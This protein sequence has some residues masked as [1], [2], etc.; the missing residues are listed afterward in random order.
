MDFNDSQQEAEFRKEAR[1][2]LE[3]NAEKRS[4]I[5]D[6]PNDTGSQVAVAGAPETVKG[7]LEAAQAALENAKVWQKKKA[8]AGFAAIL[9]PKEF[10]GYGGSPIQQVVY[11]QEEHDFLVPSGYFEI[12]IGMLGPTMMVWGKDEDKKRYLPK[13]I[14]GEEIWCQLFSEPSAG[15]DLAGIKMKAEKD[16][17][18]W[19]LNGQKVWTSGAHFADF[20]MI[21]AR[22]D[23]SALKHKGLT[24]FYLDMKTPGIEVR[25]IKQISGTS[26]FNEVFFNDVRIPDSQRLG[27]EGEGW[28]VALTTLMNERLA[29]GDPPG[30]DF[31]QIFEA[32]KELEV[33]DGL[34]IKNSEVRQKM[35][36]WYVQSRGLQYTKY[37]SITALSKG[38]TPGPEL[39][40]SKL[41]TAS[42]MQ[43][44]SAYALELMDSSGMVHHD[45][46]PVLKNLFQNGYFFS[47][48][49]RIA[50]GTDEVLRNIIA[51]RVLGLPQDER[52]DKKVP[53][54]ELPSGKN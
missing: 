47:A 37:R 3:A 38:Q 49:M 19:V 32:T 5:A 52:T 30:L 46:N 14:T 13:M 7:G 42:K 34:A 23:P 48:A 28:K 24:Y 22:S 44:V 51:E 40:I 8:D 50:G 54:N 6:K 21:V 33:E 11:S 29:V 1:E 17:D 27:E 45:Q 20:G 53:F 43:D 10:G 26:N 15:S 4:I 35:A 31:D 39:S 41:V 2:F 16:G 25:P 12:G 9:W 36:D 18:E